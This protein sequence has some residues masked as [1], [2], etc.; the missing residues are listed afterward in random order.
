MGTKPAPIPRGR[1]SRTGR[2]ATLSVPHRIPG[3]QLLKH[4]V[5]EFRYLGSEATDQPAVGLLMPPS[6]PTYRD[7]DLFAVMDQHLP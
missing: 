4:S 5:Y 7:G 2:S 1:M 6:N 3:G